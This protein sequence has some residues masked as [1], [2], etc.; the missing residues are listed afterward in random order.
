MQHINQTENGLA[1]DWAPDGARLSQQKQQIRGGYWDQFYSSDQ[2]MN[3]QPPSQ[4]AAFVASEYGS[5]PLFVDVGCGNGRDTLFFAQLGHETVGI[6]ASDSA[7]SLCQKSIPG[8]QKEKHPFIVRDVMDL[9][10]D[11]ALIESI[12]SCRKV[13]YSRFFLHAIDEAEETAFF[14]FA[15]KCMQPDDVIAIEFRSHLD[16]ST[17]KVTQAHYRRYIHPDPLIANVLNDYPASLEYLACGLGMAKYKQDDAHVARIVF[18][19]S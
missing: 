12:S 11:R 16:Q 4:F 5:H 19:K 8:D 14:D 9:Q 17:P 15:F 6:D 7:I 10:D 18:R 1:L 13:I 2:K 3:L